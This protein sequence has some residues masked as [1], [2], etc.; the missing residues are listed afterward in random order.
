[1]G[2]G[3]ELSLAADDPV[4]IPHLYTQYAN[5][6]RG[7]TDLRY[8]HERATAILSD[9]KVEHFVLNSQ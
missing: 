9:I 6:Q 5:F 8:A 7:A 4:A 3:Q 2:A 1:V